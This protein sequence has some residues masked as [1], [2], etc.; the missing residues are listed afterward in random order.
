MRT[1]FIAFVV[2]TPG[3]SSPALAQQTPIIPS[4][5]WLKS[6]VDKPLSPT[7]TLSAGDQPRTLRTTR[8]RRA[9]HPRFEYRF[10]RDGV[11]PTLTFRVARHMT[12]ELG[13][14]VSVNF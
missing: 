5:I 12:P 8:Y 9:M 11:S 7:W 3:I 10:N 2:C 14:G 4:I 6:T 1:L 13:L